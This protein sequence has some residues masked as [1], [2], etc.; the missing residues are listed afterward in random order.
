MRDITDAATRRAEWYATACR[1][2]A[3]AFVT[4]V[5][6]GVVVVHRYPFVAWGLAVL[7]PTAILGVV[8]ALHR[9]DLERG[10]NDE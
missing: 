4:A 10:G 9:V 2:G 6:F 1:S 5:L 8:Y 3:V 7:I